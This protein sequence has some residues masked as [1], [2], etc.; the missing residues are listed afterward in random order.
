[1]GRDAEVCYQ[2][3]VPRKSRRQK[4]T[5]EIAIKD[6]G[7]QWQTVPGHCLRL[8]GSENPVSDLTKDYEKGKR[9]GKDYLSKILKQNS[10]ILPNLA[11]SKTM[12]SDH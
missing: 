11:L 8:S 10:S 1:M 7:L 3:R 2:V 5:A 6:L 4:K 12:G 9:K